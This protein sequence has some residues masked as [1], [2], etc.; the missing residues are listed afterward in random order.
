MIIA[1]ISCGNGMVD[2]W[3]TYVVCNR[4][5]H[6]SIYRIEIYWKLL[7]EFSCNFYKILTYKTTVRVEDGRFYLFYFIFL[8][9]HI[10]YIFEL[11]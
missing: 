9:Y 6:S 4:T 2:S 11:S 8:F 5:C 10:F 3:T 7:V 1:C